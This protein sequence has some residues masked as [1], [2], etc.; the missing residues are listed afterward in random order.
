MQAAS[1]L[2]QP[3]PRNSEGGGASIVAEGV[4]KRFGRNAVVLEGV[5][6]SIRAGEFVAIVGPSGCGKSTLLRMIAGLERSDEGRL[7]VAQAD[8]GRR[9]QSAFVFQEPALLPWRTVTENIAVPLEL[10]RRPR[11]ERLSRVRESLQLIGLSAND[12]EK[13]PRQLSGGMKMRVSLARALVT[14]PDL[15]LLDEPFGALDDLLRQRLNE[16]LHRL[17]STQRWTALFVTHNVSEAVFLAERVL[18]MASN[19][20]RIA[21]EFAVPFPMPRNP[22]LRAEAEFARIVGEMSGALRNGV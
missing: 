14:E 5:S 18:V 21:A 8:E 20:G 9:T 19:P 10:A 17:W 12:A 6:F 4:T 13:R 15:L 1:A 16:E 3:V 22:E 11:A 7:A 2:P